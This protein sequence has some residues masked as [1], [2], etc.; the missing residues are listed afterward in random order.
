MPVK[1]FP[2]FPVTVVPFI[3]DPNVEKVNIAPVASTVL[4]LI[5]RLFVVFWP[6]RLDP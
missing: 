3:P 1:L 6:P 2:A 5:V 4:T